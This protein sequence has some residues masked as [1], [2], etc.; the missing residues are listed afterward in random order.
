MKEESKMLERYFKILQFCSCGFFI[1]I[2]TY[3]P[4]EKKNHNYYLHKYYREY[5]YY[6]IKRK[7]KTP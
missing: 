3:F 4:Q 7:L 5:F 2:E 6:T 1:L